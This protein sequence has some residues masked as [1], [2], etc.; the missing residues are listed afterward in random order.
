MEDDIGTSLQILRHTI[1]EIHGLIIGVIPII[2]CSARGFEFVR[3]LLR[4]NDY[5]LL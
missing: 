5:S 3:E 2:K 4:V 1:P